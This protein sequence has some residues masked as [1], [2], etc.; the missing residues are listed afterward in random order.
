MWDIGDAYKKLQTSSSNIGNYLD[1]PVCAVLPKGQQVWIRLYLNG[2]TDPKYIAIYAHMHTPERSQFQGEVK[3]T[4]VDQTIQEPFDHMI[5]NCSG[6]MSH[7]GDRIGST[8]F[9]DKSRLFMASSPFIFR[10]SI[11]LLIQFRPNGQTDFGN[12]PKCLQH[13]M[14][15]K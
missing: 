10:D 15:N 9:A 13:A 8:K 12:L 3:F 6:S 2:E 14:G 11:K 4:I 7:I 1:S 5:K